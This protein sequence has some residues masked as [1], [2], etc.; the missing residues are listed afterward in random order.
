MS[1][2][3]CIII[4]LVPGVLYPQPGAKYVQTQWGFDTGTASCVT[5]WNT[6]PS[7]WPKKGDPSPD[8]TGMFATDIERADHESRGCR[9][10]NVTYKGLVTNSALGGISKLVRKCTASMSTVVAR[11]GVY[12]QLSA[13]RYTDTFLTTTPPTLSGQGGVI[14]AGHAPAFGATIAFPDGHVESRAGFWIL[15]SRDFEPVVEGKALWSV[16]E[17][18]CFVAIVVA[19]SP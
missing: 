17:N 11:P 3:D 13:P 7:T 15:E 6:S 16:R 5:H 2:G 1:A 8:Y 12:A 19:P 18:A 4:G 14:D 9:E 10:F